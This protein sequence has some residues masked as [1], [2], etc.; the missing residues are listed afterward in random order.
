MASNK[1][2]GFDPEPYRL[3]LV[4]SSKEGYENAKIANANLELI[5]ND[6][7]KD[8][9]EFILAGIKDN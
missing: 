5:A 6:D 7:L 2:F 8:Y 9:D 4:F 1:S 3:I